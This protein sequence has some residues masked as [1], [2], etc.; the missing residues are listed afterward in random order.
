MHNSV[1]IYL[2]HYYIY[3]GVFWEGI[4][5]GVDKWKVMSACTKWVFKALS[6]PEKLNKSVFD[7]FFTQTDDSLPVTKWFGMNYMHILSDN[8]KFGSF[9][10]VPSMKYPPIV[11]AFVV[12]YDEQQDL[13]HYP[14]LSDLGFQTVLG[15]E[16]VYTLVSNK[17]QHPIGVGLHC[18]FLPDLRDLERLIMVDEKISDF[19]LEAFRTLPLIE[20]LEQELTEA[21]ACKDNNL[22]IATVATLSIAIE[23]ACKVVLEQRNITY[24]RVRDGLNDLLNHLVRNGFLS[25]KDRQACLALKGLRNAVDHGHSGILTIQNA[26]LFFSSGSGLIQTI[27]Q[28]AIHD[29]TT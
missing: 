25:E 19:S 17:P 3:F 24:Q 1:V 27:L 7:R 10:Y 12:P 14:S 4:Y 28:S 26:E 20:Q 5:L 22:A 15:T 23:T 11:K 2:E 16:C 9:P 29:G 13:S 21:R 6:M 8:L 18:V